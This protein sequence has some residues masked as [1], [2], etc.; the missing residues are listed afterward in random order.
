MSTDRSIHVG[1]V[2]KPKRVSYWQSGGGKG[3]GQGRQYAP[4]LRAPEGWRVRSKRPSRARVEGVE[5]GTWDNRVSLI[6]G[7]SICSQNI[8]FNQLKLTKSLA[9]Q[10]FDCLLLPCC[11]QWRTLTN[12]IVP[13]DILSLKKEKNTKKDLW[14]GVFWFVALRTN[15]FYLKYNRKRA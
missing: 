7:S 3:V 9:L 13:K 6:R 11:W 12:T 4:R 14:K 5:I 1:N 15:F 2:R 10:I 8:N